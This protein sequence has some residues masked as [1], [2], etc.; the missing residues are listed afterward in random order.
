MCSRVSK[1]IHTPVINSHVFYV[2]SPHFVVRSVSLDQGKATHVATWARVNF[3]SHE[4]PRAIWRWWIG[5]STFCFA[6][7]VGDAPAILANTAFFAVAMYVLQVTNELN[8]TLISESKDCDST[9]TCE[10]FSH[11]RA[12]Y[13][14]FSMC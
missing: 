2:P 6:Y 12:K 9:V 13:I 5:A 8:S 10:T 1:S 11:D 4:E 14:H 3:N 7:I